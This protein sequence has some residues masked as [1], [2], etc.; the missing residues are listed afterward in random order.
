[1]QRFDK[2]LIGLLLVCAFPIFFSL[3]AGT[4]WFYFDKNESNVLF[5]VATGFQSLPRLS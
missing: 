3:A 4:T 1:M 2:I 5:Y